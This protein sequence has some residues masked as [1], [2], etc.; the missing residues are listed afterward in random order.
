MNYDTSINSDR[1]GGAFYRDDDEL[2]SLTPPDEEE[3]RSRRKLI[4]ISLVVLAAIVAIVA[5][6]VN[7]GGDD[8]AA[9][10]PATQIPAVTVV[11]P[12][13][14]TVTNRISTTGTL[15]ARR[16][17]PVGSVGE[18]GQV[19]QVF[20][21]EGEW[22]RQ[23]QVLVSIDRSV[24]NRQVQG[25]S[26]QVEVARADAQLAE[27]NLERALKLVDRGF[28]STADV[29]RLTATR[30]AAVARV[31]VAEAQVAESRARNARLSITAPASGLVLMRSVEP[32]QVVGPGSGPLFMIARGGERELQAAVSETDLT[33]IGVGV[34]AEVTPVGSEQTFTGQ[35][36]QVAPTIEESSRQ[37]IARIALS[38][39]SALR[40]GGFASAV[41][42][43][44]AVSAPVLPESAIL[45]DDQGSY[46]YIVRKDDT[47]AI[48]RVETGLV[49]P[50]GI[51]I[52]SGLNGTERV[53]L[54]AGG[55]LNPGD[56]V[57]P[58][59]EPRPQ[60]ATPTA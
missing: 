44:G 15:S 53:V 2:S 29:D 40:P 50:D 14:T 3:T 41:I 7:R 26:A 28:I 17:I 4:I 13:R 9:A 12:G 47:V 24:Q 60:G 48:R 46:V 10:G 27:A 42:N 37:G 51:V 1:A 30:N 34:T 38:Y 59:R 33:Q 23:G 20:A 31:R 32:G 39:D 52:A 19:S 49:T 21:E 58:R 43:A 56:K 25:Q 11:V 5:L 57:E 22:V 8:V 18:G 36:W 35:I 45:S 16:A 55:F 54:L 6:F